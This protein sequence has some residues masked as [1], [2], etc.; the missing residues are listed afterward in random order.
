MPT[1]R[2]CV[3]FLLLTA[4][5]A[6]Q[7]EVSPLL[8]LHEAARW[9]YAVEYR[10]A[11][12]APTGPTQLE[13]VDEGAFTMPDG[14]R[15]HQLRR[16]LGDAAPTFACW[17]VRD[18]GIHEHRCEHPARRGTMDLDAVPLRLLALPLRTGARWQWLGCLAD[19]GDEHADWRHQATL[20]AT[21]AAVTVPAG[22]FRAGHV[23]IRSERP[24]ALRERELWFAPGT[25]IVREELRT[26]ALRE[27]RELTAF[28]PGRAARH[29]ALLAHLERSLQ[30]PKSKPYN[31]PPWI[32][33]IDDAPEAMLLPGR[34]CVA[35]AETWTRCYYVDGDGAIAFDYHEADRVGVAAQQAFGG[36]SALPPETVPAEALALLLARTH[37]EVCNLRRLQRVPPTLEPERAVPRDGR[38]AH[39]ELRGGAPD[40]TMRRVAVWL[41][42]ARSSAIEIASDAVARQPLDRW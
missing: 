8:P 37:A 25:G 27:V 11:R 21:D 35:R 20:L 7:A 13:L 40:G 3:P 18:D 22:T 9:T 14:T 17:S 36:D 39:V 23:R 6:A 26:A 41:N 12:D 2:P 32:A 42:L 15:V 5:A 1:M 4:G 10:T 30:D 33:E 19:A 34:I 16:T 24:G 38:F 29:E 31:N 28:T